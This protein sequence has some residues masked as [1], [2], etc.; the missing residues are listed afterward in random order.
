MATKNKPLNKVFVATGKI[1]VQQSNGK[2][3][4]EEQYIVL[5]EELA[6]YIGATYTNKPPAPKKV[7]IAK[8]ALKGRT[9]QREHSVSVSGAKYELAYI[10]GT[11]TK[12]GTNKKV[13]KL[14]WIP[15]HIPKGISLREFIKVIATKFKKKPFLLKTPAGVSTRF[16]N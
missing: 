13:V 7:V 9:I 15:I 5:S 4:T 10:D 1:P 16:I 2:I 14:K 8:G 11:T 12:P 3:I 6:K